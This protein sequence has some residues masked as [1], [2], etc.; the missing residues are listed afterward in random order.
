MMKQLLLFFFFALHLGAAAALAE[1]S[2]PA[3]PTV[4]M[5]LGGLDAF[6]YS[7]AKKRVLD[8]DA[9]LKRLHLDPKACTFRQAN[10]VKDYSY[11]GIGPCLMKAFLRSMKTDVL[12]GV[13]Y[14][15]I[16]DQQGQLQRVEIEWRPPRGGWSVVIK[17]FLEMRFEKQ[18]YGFRESVFGEKDADELR[19]Q[20]FLAG[21][22]KITL[23]EDPQGVQSLA[24]QSLNPWV[25]QELEQAQSVSLHLQAIGSDHGK[26]T[27]KGQVVAASRE[28][29][30]QDIVVQLQTNIN[31][32]LP[33]RPFFVQAH[34][35]LHQGEGAVP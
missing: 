6:A 16:P 13:I 7:F 21:D 27:Y 4:T 24:N 12:A 29:K 10:P 33:S 31:I 5:N 15:W 17:E 30:A 20:D 11:I 2:A 26:V 34:G 32:V 14:A 25:R 3:S 9:T 18:L 35:Q 23:P 28:G 8:I 19:Y 22:L 1:D